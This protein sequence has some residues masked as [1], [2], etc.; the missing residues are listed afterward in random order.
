MNALLLTSGGL[1]AARVMNAWLAAG[2]GIAA[3]WIGHRRKRLQRDRVPRLLFL[4]YTPRLGLIARPTQKRS[5]S[6]PN[7]RQPI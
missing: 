5:S 6:Q 1:I 7:N 2:N 4:S 3:I